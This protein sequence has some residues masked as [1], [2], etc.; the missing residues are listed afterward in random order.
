MLI[1]VCGI[2]NTINLSSIAELKCSWIGL[3]F[4]PKSKRYVQYDETFVQAARQIEQQRVGVF[5]QEDCNR[6]LQIVEQYSLD[7][8]QLHGDEDVGYC[9]MVQAQVPVIKV[10]RVGERFDWSQTTAFD[11]VDYFLF[12]TYTEAFGGSGKAFDWNQIQ[13]YNGKTP[14]LLSGGI[15][16]EHWQH[17]NT[18]NHPLCIGVD[19]NSKFETAPGIKDVEAVKLFIENVKK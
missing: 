4:Y 10:F 12:D 15:G 19:I 18:F 13:N 11:F 3:N 17:L 8:V 1:K 6:L 2:N 5:V 9:Q 14:F 7:I 16:P